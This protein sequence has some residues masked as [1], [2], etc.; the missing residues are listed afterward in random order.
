M[1]GHQTGVLPS[2]GLPCKRTLSSAQFKH[3][4]NIMLENYQSGN[5]KTVEQCTPDYEK[6]INQATEKL[7]K[8]R[9]LQIAIFNYTGYVKFRDKMAELL[10]ELVSRER[11]L[12]HIIDD[13]IKDQ[14][15]AN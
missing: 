11:L 10:G 14:Q 5:T 8:N 3:K 12:K 4:G 6:M 2:W 13:L 9:A 1:V 7:N 15:K